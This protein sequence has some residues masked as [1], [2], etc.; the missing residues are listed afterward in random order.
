MTHLP[1]ARRSGFTLV[2]MLVVITIIAIL[3]SL[4]LPALSAAREAARSSQCKS[5]LRNF[6]VSFATFADRDSLGRF[7]SGAY[8]GKRDGCVDTVG[9]VADAVNGGTCRPQELLCPSNASKGSEKLNDYFGVPTSKAGE[10]ADPSLIN[11]GA[12][13]ATFAAYDDSG[14]GKTKGE[15]IAQHFLEKGYG[16]NYVSSWFLVR[17]GPALSTNAS[18]QTIYATGSKIKG[19]VF[20][21][22]PLAR[23]TTDNCP[24]TSSKIALLADANIGDS[25]EAILSKTV[26]GFLP[27]GHRLLESFSDGPAGRVCKPGALDTWGVGADVVVYDPASP[28]TSVY[29]QE[30]PAKGISPPYPWN[31]LQD[32]RDFGPVHGGSKGGVCNVL[33]ADGSVKDF[34]DTNGDG[35]LNPGFDT[36]AVTNID[37]VGYADS[38]VEM[39]PQEIFNGVFIAKFVNKGNLDQ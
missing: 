9:W 22:G 11:V 29:A 15:F 31:H 24:H 14:P 26:P 21:Q 23:S 39:G 25:K 7:C 16:T 28:N 36:S 5:N 27:A 4:A 12:C 30:Q 20:T 8:D 38:K 1:R 37:A 33:M 3:A 17:G 34:Y 2:E 18:G 19:L 10:T 6:Y 35:Y 13:G 32:W